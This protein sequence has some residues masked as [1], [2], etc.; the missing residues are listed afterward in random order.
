MNHRTAPTSAA[1]PPTL[2]AT[3]PTTFARLNPVFGCGTEVVWTTGNSVYESSWMYTRNSI[4]VY[5]M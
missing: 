3:T 2:P 4:P 5:I 1:K